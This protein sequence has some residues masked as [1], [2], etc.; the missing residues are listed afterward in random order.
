[1]SSF[2]FLSFLFLLSH[3]NF[4]TAASGFRHLFLQRSAEPGASLWGEH[5]LQEEK[6]S[7][8]LEPSHLP[9][10]YYHSLSLSHLSPNFHP[11]SPDSLP[12]PQRRAFFFAWWKFPRVRL[13]VSLLHALE[14][15][16]HPSPPSWLLIL[17]N[18]Y[19]FRVLRKPLPLLTK[20]GSLPWPWW[21][22]WLEHC[23]AHQKVVGLI[24]SQGTYLGCRLSL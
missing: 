23:S 3:F 15:T 6:E 16:L 11:R 10:L 14:Q 17:K 19:V 7:Y 20:L 5:S 21:L 8:S 13:W 1:M 9:G 12:Y 18:S 24:P 22:G 4:S 2:F